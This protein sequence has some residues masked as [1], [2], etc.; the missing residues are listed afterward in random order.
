MTALG[1][2]QQI[3]FVDVSLPASLLGCSLCLNMHPLSDT[4]SHALTGLPGIGVPR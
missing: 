4:C 3:L 2:L 1:A